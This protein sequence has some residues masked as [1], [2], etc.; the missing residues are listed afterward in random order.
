MQEELKNLVKQIKENVPGYIGVCVAEMSTGD[1]L[2]ADSSDSEFDPAMASAYNVQIINE[3]RKAIEVLGLNQ[4]LHDIQFNLDSHIHLVNIFPSGD[5]FIY[6]A[7]EESKANLA[8]TRKLLK[9]YKTE[10]Q[11]KL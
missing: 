5:Y 9:T 7:L 8:I 11:D 6:L 1:S 3:K 4:T 2:V 10:I